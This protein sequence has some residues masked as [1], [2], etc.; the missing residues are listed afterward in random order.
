MPSDFSPPPADLLQRGVR[1]VAGDIR[2]R[3]AIG[4]AGFG[5]LALLLAWHGVSI[6]LREMWVE[7]HATRQA[8]ARVV[9]TYWLVTPPIVPIGG[10]H[11]TQAAS[12]RLHT[13]LAFAADGK[14]VEARFVAK[15][16][17][18]DDW[19]RR[20]PSLA[21]AT[22]LRTIEFRFPA[23]YL[24]RLRATKASFWP[25]PCDEKLPLG[26]AGA[27][28]S[29]FDFFWLVIDQPLAAT[30]ILWRYAPGPAGVPIR[31]QPGAPRRA[32]PSAFA[33][34][35]LVLRLFPIGIFSLF[36]ALG[37]LFF[38]SGARQLLPA[39]LPRRWHA[40][41]LAGAVLMVPM[42]AELLAGFGAL[43]AP[44]AP[45]ALTSIFLDAMPEIASAQPL[46]P[47][48]SPQPADLVA[49]H[50]APA[51]SAYA[52]LLGLLRLDS[53][54][55]SFDSDDAAYR[56]VL[57]AIEARLRS[58]SDSEDEEI[59]SS[60]LRLLDRHRQR[61]EEA[62]LGGA[63]AIAT[64]PARPAALRHLAKRLVS[65]TLSGLEP[66]PGDFAT[67]AR[68]DEVRRFASDPDP[69]NARHARQYLER[70]ARYHRR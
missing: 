32:L 51:T 63:A 6:P 66:Y 37:L 43:V 56:A 10:E 3:I 11:G 21:G 62:L 35:P 28:G 8:T 47:E 2:R 25:L 57:D 55:R 22:T 68:V 5:T 29:D 24:A 67:A 4:M 7:S 19:W 50:W 36:G 38:T 30:A 64:D 33:P 52:E 42:W 39:G 12:L 60:A 31:Y 70:A 54:G 44:S 27:C 23:P 14:T 61:F 65:R 20:L 58:A 26:S 40:V 48:P 59:V 49:V 41:V 9:D 18:P 46:R 45:L 53:G 15:S 17:S 1:R 13:T 34:P 16:A 69:D